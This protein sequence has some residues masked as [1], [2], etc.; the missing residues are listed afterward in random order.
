MQAKLEA[1]PIQAGD[2]PETYDGEEKLLDEFDFYPR[3]SSE[4][5]EGG[6]L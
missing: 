5:K 4:Q 2:V 3:T 6:T 1:L